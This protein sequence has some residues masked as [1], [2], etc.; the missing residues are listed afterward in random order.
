VIEFVEGV[1]RLRE[2]KLGDFEEIKGNSR[3]A[4][5]EEGLPLRFCAY[6]DCFI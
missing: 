6:L 5:D 1:L 4:R 3:V 2:T